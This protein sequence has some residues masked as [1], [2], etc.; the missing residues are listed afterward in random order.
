VLGQLTDIKGPVELRGLTIET[1][2]SLGRC[3]PD[4]PLRF[5]FDWHG[6]CFDG[7]V[8]RDTERLVLSLTAHVSIVPCSAE[9]A[10]RR[11]TML[12]LLTASEESGEGPALSLADNGTLSLRRRIALGSDA[13]LTAT[14]LIAATTSAVLSSAALLDLIA[15]YGLGAGAAGAPL[16]SPSAT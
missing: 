10:E 16:S 7:S 6:A 4:L 9:D 12:A 13:A 2:G 8:S 3:A 1:D 15:E 11:R 14:V 5:G